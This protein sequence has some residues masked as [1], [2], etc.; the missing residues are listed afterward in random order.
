MSKGD[1][2]FITRLGEEGPASRRVLPWLIARWHL[3]A[4]V[5]G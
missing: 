2:K 3:A 4:Q 5:P 1:G